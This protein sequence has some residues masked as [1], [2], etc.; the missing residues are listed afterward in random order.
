[1]ASIDDELLMDEEETRREMAFIRKQLPQD[2]K[3]KYSDEQLLWMLDEIVEYYVSSGVL[4]TNDDEIDI[5]MEK[6]AAYVC[7]QSLKQG[8]GELDPQEVSFV[9]EADLDFQEQA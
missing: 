4:D 7:E 3:D 9:V 2:M 8:R 5:D 1:M 6:V